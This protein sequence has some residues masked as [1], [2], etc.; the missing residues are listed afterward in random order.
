VSSSIEQEFEAACLLCGAPG[1]RPST[2]FGMRWDGRQFDYLDC[3]GC[4]ARFVFPLPTSTDFER[5]YT[6]SDYHDIHYAELACGQFARSLAALAGFVAPGARV[7]DFGCGN[8]EFLK[9]AA[10]AGYR[11]EGI[12]LDAATRERAA[13]NSGC[14]VHSLDEVMAGAPKYDAIHLGDVL[15][16]LPD[17]AG[18]MRELEMILAPDGL[19]LVEG[20]LEEN[21]SLVAWTAATVRRAK[22]ALRRSSHAAGPP[23]HLTRTSAAS[24]RRFFEQTL[25]YEL[26]GFDIYE[27]GWPYA[28][29]WHDIIVPR[30]AST[31]IRGLIGK[32]AIGLANVA[33]IAGLKMGDRFI[34]VLRPRPQEH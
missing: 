7:L 10:G 15:E 32:T 9:E 27:S 29:R 1:K 19:F 33:N 4:G 6:R 8:G 3:T 30:R 17:P 18:T 24:Q 23:T 25:G 28:T 26:C 13:E 20:P 5:I 31:A 11:A 21:R 2:P 22:T 34:A 16:H 14:P 12:E